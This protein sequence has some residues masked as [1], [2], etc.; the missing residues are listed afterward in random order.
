MPKIE[1]VG[2]RAFQD[3]AQLA[4]IIFP[5]CVTRIGKQ[6]FLGTT[7]LQFI[8]CESTT[9]PTL[10]EDAFPNKSVP[11]YVPEESLKLYQGANGWCEF[12]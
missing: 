2:D 6:S 5:S 1:V 3:C 10:G 7:S 9:I 11:L 8:R 12:L 4:S